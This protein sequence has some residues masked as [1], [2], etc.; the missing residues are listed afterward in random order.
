MTPHGRDYTT[1]VLVLG[2]DPLILHIILRTSAENKWLSSLFCTYVWL[3]EVN[4]TRGYFRKG[5]RAPPSN[6]SRRA[7]VRYE[8]FRRH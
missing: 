6:C 5:K 1:L 3:V 2:G 8:A 4:S 7:A